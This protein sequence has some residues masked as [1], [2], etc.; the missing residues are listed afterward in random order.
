MSQKRMVTVPSE[1]RSRLMSCSSAASSVGFATG[2]AVL[3]SRRLATRASC[4]PERF[5]RLLTLMPAMTAYP[6]T[7]IRG[8]PGTK[9]TSRSER[10]RP[11]MKEKPRS[12]TSNPSGTTMSMPPQKA[13]AVISTS[14]PSISALRRSMSQPPM[15]ATAFVFPLMRQRPLVLWPLMTATCQR[16]SFLGVPV[17]GSG[18]RS[19]TGRASGRSA[20]TATRSARV[21]AERADPTLSE[22]SSSVSRPSTTCSR[23]WVTVRSRSASATRSA[24]APALPRRRGRAVR[25]R[26]VSH[27]GQSARSACPGLDLTTHQMPISPAIRLIARA[28]H[29]ECSGIRALSAVGPIGHQGIH[30]Q[31]RRQGNQGRGLPRRGLD[32]ARRRGGP[33]RSALRPWSHA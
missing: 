9:G 15:T 16:R 25:N 32:H 10:S 3:S 26:Q 19:P 31:W 5:G 11:P 29:F 20:M 8:E 1:G 21:L 28:R 27:A 33:A 14:G 23:S 30:G 13:K 7:T 4:L 18:R 17:E 24:S 2:S 6:F 12:S 22:N